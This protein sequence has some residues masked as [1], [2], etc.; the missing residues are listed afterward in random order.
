MT[1]LAV[2]RTKEAAVL[3]VDSMAIQYSDEG[4][5]SYVQNITK[6][7]R[8]APDLSLIHI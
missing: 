3:G 1:Q 2:V 6:L 8:L 4:E 5:I 7:L